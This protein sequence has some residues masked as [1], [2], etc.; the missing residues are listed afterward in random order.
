[1]LFHDGHVAAVDVKRG[2]GLSNPPTSGPGWRFE[3]KARP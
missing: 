2:T 3:Y 1:M